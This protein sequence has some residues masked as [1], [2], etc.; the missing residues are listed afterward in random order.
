MK[1]NAAQDKAFK[2]TLIYFVIGCAWILFSD[3][4][5]MLSFPK[6]NQVLYYSIAKGT[7]YVFITSVLIYYLTYLPLKEALDGKEALSRVNAELKNAN[8][9]YKKLNQD[10]ADKQAFLKSLMDSIPDF[11]FYKDT[12]GVYLSCNAAFASFAGKKEQDIAG[13]TDREL[14]PPS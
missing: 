7:I 4:F 5:G 12:N 9:L 3:R 8:E 11:V 2:I 1:N 10:Y 13:H 14:F 6:G